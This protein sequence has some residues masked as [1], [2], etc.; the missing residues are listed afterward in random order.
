MTQRNVRNV[1]DELSSINNIVQNRVEGT[2]D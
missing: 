1:F 2:S